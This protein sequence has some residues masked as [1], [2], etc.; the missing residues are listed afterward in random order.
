MFHEFERLAGIHPTLGRGWYGVRRTATDLAE[1]IEKDQRVLNSLSGHSDS[2][3]RRSVYQEKNR[4]EV[5]AQAAVT[6]EELR[7]SAR[8]ARN[9]EENGPQTGP[10]NEA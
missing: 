4:P 8:L 3:I 1:D 9:G 6:R 5:L 2:A 7:K 10:Q